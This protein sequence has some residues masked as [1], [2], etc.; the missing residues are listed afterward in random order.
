M[1]DDSRHEESLILDQKVNRLKINRVALVQ[2]L[3]VE[4]VLPSLIRKGILSEDEATDVL[5]RPHHSDQTRY[6]LDLLPTKEKK[7][8]WYDAF[9]QS[10]KNPY[11]TDTDTRKRYQILVEFLDNAIIPKPEKFAMYGEPPGAKRRQLPHYKRLPHISST[12]D[13]SRSRDVVVDDHNSPKSNTSDRFETPSETHNNQSNTKQEGRMDIC[14]DGAYR[15]ND[16]KQDDGLRYNDEKMTD[17]NTHADMHTDNCYHTWIPE[18]SHF[19]SLVTEPTSHFDELG[20]SS[21]P[22]D[23]DMLRKEVNCLRKFRNLEKII[24]FHRRAKLPDGFVL[25][26]SKVLFEITEDPNEYRIYY[27]YM[28]QIRSSFDIDVGKILTLSYVCYLQSLPDGSAKEE[29]LRDCLV[30]V[31]FGLYDFLSNYGQYHMAETILYNLVHF[32]A[33][34][35]ALETWMATW[36][37]CIK[38]MSCRTTNVNFREADTI[39]HTALEVGRKIKLMSFGK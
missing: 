17:T 34:Y 7:V 26:L 21:D 24:A 25:C 38:I 3:K 9:K 10:L 12:D 36:E 31:G 19:A 23:H 27:K 4:H 20:Q 22:E 32:L 5:K 14:K 29:P 37:A 28:R 6:L 8:N 35:Q 18:V 30:N 33:S 15:E 2:E 11:V 16:K 13:F 39:Y 1:A